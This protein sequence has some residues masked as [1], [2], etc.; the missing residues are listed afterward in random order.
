MRLKL[1]PPLS[2][3]L[4]FVFSAH[5]S[6][7]QVSPAGLV[8]T[9]PI[10]FGVGVS[11]FEPDFDAGR[12]LGGSLWIDYN[13]QWLPG[14]LNG[15]GLEV[16]GRDLSFDRAA[17][18]PGNL[19]EDVASGGAIYAWNHYRFV[20]PYGKFLA[21][22]GNVDYENA[23]GAR[24]HDSRTVTSAGGGVEVQA[25]HRVWARADY[26]YQWWPDFYMQQF[27]NNGQLNPQGITVG[28]SYHFNQRDY[29]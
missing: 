24:F 17:D 23:E 11:S 26:E 12:I 21:G 13:P 10:T 16:E 5:L 8:K 3:A 18:Q 1:I 28:V 2:L 9:I 29:R 6:F 20:R 19:R 22:F 14:R 25:F 7:A 27:T 15:L 4:L